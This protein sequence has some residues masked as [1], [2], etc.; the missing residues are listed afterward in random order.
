MVFSREIILLI[1]M[2]Q[3]INSYTLTQYPN[4]HIAIG[5]SATENRVR[6]KF[7]ASNKFVLSWDT[8][9]SGTGGFIKA[10]IFQFSGST[11]TNTGPIIPVEPFAANKSNENHYSTDIGTFS[12]GGFIITWV[13][14]LSN[15]PTGCL[16]T[17]LGD[18]YFIRGSYHDA[19]GALLAGSPKP[20]A[21]GVVTS[22]ELLAPLVS[23]ADNDFFSVTY[24][25]GPCCGSATSLLGKSY[26]SGGIPLFSTNNYYFMDSGLCTHSG[27]L[28]FT[29]VKDQNYIAAYSCNSMSNNNNVVFATYNLYESNSGGTDRLLSSDTGNVENNPSLAYDSIND[30][31][32]YCYES[33]RSV[34]FDIYFNLINV[35][36]SNRNMSTDV[37]VNTNITGPQVNCNITPLSDGNA[38]V[39]WINDTA[40]KDIRFQIVDPN[41]NLILGENAIVGP[42]VAQVSSYSVTQKENSIIFAWTNNSSTSYMTRYKF[43][44]CYG[45]N[46]LI[47]RNILTQVKFTALAATDTNITFKS[48]PSA[49]ALVDAASTAL[50]N[51]GAYIKTNVYCL[52]SQT[53]YI[54]MN[55]I[56]IA[57]AFD[58]VC[59]V[60]LNMCFIS[61]KICSAIGNPMTHNCSS[62]DT[63]NNYY[64]HPMSPGNCYLKTDNLNFYYPDTTA[65][66]WKPCDPSCKQCTGPSNTECKVLLGVTQCDQVNGW[67]PVSDQ[68]G[69]CAK[70]TLTGYIFISNHFD[71][72][73]SSC[74]S[75]TG[76]GDTLDHKCISC[77]S[78]Y[79]K[80]TPASTMCQHALPG[81]Y[82]D[83]DTGI[84]TKCYLSCQTCEKKGDSSEHNCT[85]CASGHFNIYQGDSSMCYATLEKYYLDKDS[86]FKK[87]YKLCATCDELG[88]AKDPKCTACASDP[89]TCKPCTK[90]IHIDSCVEFCPTGYASDTN[91]YCVPC[92]NA[93][94]YLLDFTCYDKCP[95]GYQSDSNSHCQP[96]ANTNKQTDT[97]TGNGDGVADSTVKLCDPNPCEN[98]GTCSIKANYYVCTCKEGFSGTDCQT[99]ISGQS[100]TNP[101][102]NSMNIDTILG[103]LSDPLTP[104]NVKILKDFLAI[105]NDTPMTSEQCD[106]IYNLICKRS[107]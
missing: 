5:S 79:A 28:G 76:V 40:P 84:M 20:M 93:G 89:L 44:H 106:K 53:T 103:S 26:N 12:N 104:E 50:L 101:S 91:S 56:Y 24:Y 92:T 86:F 107:F 83:N 82:A 77:K 15:C 72:C 68:P 47:P 105:A 13:N 94:K 57:H 43:D 30:K 58:N 96:I 75:C 62:C 39:S 31:V 66:E 70:G 85:Q 14:K 38:I 45:F 49:P 61:C 73:Y 7:T 27:R 52:T 59:L 81:Y 16:H 88:N 71:P 78:G 32:W 37:R 6:V 35:A 22:R 99:E 67:Y 69:K 51:G 97:K 10:Q 25:E 100:S 87:C 95:D 90:F 54:S 18:Q 63:F 46:V 23:V 41:G 34:D 11:I 19:N 21:N 55:F 102:Q 65:L 74:D 2:F 1:L 80:D 29:N 42:D 9:A 36:G 3:M 8:E 48:L 64:P 17:S 33:N 4:S 60:N 98:N